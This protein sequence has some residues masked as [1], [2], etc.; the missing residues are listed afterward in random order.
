MHL[1]TPDIPPH[2]P[3]D[4]ISRLGVSRIPR[5]RLHRH[6]LGVIVRLGEF[7]WENILKRLIY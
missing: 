7:V 3:A 4:S 1:L 6:G 2:C 5:A